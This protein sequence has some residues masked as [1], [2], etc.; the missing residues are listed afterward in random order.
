MI[1]SLF[2]SLRFHYGIV[3]VWVDQT[4]SHQCF[5]FYCTMWW[6]HFFRKF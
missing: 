6:R 2:I 4:I 1:T 3:V 5:S